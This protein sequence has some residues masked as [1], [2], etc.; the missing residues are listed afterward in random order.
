MPDAIKRIVDVIAPVDDTWFYTSERLAD[1]LPDAEA[2]EDVAAGVMAMEI[3]RDL[4]EYV[5]WFRPATDRTVDWAGDPRKGEVRVDRRGATPQPTRVVRVVAAD[6]PRPLPALGEVADRGGIES[7]PI[8]AGR[9][10]RR[11]DE[12][13]LIN[14]RLSETDRLK[15]EFLATVGHE[16]RTPLNAMLGWVQILRTGALDQDRLGRA[17][18][19]IERNARAQGKLVDDLLDVSR[20]VAGKLKLAMQPIEIGG[21]SSAP[22]KASGPVLKPSRS[23]CRWRSIRRPSSW[24]TPTACS[25]SPPTC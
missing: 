6:G 25:R 17:L 11:A 16:L 4:G 22:S 5:L 13:R 12:L 21:W 14:D 2:W 18:D 20:I 3:S 9:D 10:P 15:D 1:A 8:A 7:S 23:A 19:T 24:A